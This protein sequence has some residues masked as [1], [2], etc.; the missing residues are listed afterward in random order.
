ML[1]TKITYSILFALL[2]STLTFNI[3]K[4]FSQETPVIYVDP[5][6]ITGLVPP[7]TF[8][9]EVKVANITDFYGIDIQ[10]KWDPTILEYVSHTAKI[11]VDTYPDGILHQPGITIM[12]TADPTAGTYALAYACMDPAPAFNGTGIAFEMT[13]TVI[14]TG[15]CF[16]EIYGSQLS[17]KGGTPI[18]HDVQNGYFS[19]YVPTEAKISVSPQSIIDPSL[20]PCNN[21]TININLENFVDLRS[22]EFWLGYDT[23]V[24]DTVEVNV[25]PAF[26][27]PV[28]IQIVEPDGQVLV[29]ANTSTPITGNLTIASITFHVTD[30]G[31]SVIDLHNIT[32]VDSWSEPIPYEEPEDGYFNNV[33]VAKLYV[34]PPEIIDPTLT[35]GSDFQIDIKMEN[36]FNFYSYEFGLAYDSNVITCLGAIIHPTDDDTNFHTEIIT[37]DASGNILVNLTYHPPAEPKSITAPTTIVSIYFQAKSYGSTVLD[38][39][40]TKI[41]KQSGEEISHEVEDGFFAT[42]TRDVAI[43]HVEPIRNMSYPGRMVNI[44]VVAA[45]LGDIEET[46]NVTAY[47]DENE[48]GTQTVIDLPANQN[49]TLVFTW[50][51]TGLQPCTNYTIKAEA[52]QVPYEQDII[53][54]VYIDGYVKIKMIG[55]VNGDGIIDIYDIT[56]AAGVYGS[57]EGDPNWNPEADVAPQWGIIDIYDMVT[58]ASRYGQTC[59]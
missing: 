58:I 24:L 31:E 22:F 2:I 1:K 56:A 52:T 15:Q 16:L 26:P 8:T 32:L 44:T 47:Y 33:L 23:L 50:D 12:D 13:F 42:L 49:T 55:D 37:N 41:V 57:K 51:T 29:A 5:P 48:I 46:F 38:L 27:P 35:P 11:P 53:N 14:D 18:L 28:E 36:V 17:D 6:T 9:I 39:H 34:Y 54:N 10:F 30:Q 45:N 4:A 7:Q 59:P 20:V 19:N 43:I 3:N 25:D 21:F 40:D